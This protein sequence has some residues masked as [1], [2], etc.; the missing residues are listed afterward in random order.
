MGFLMTYC[1]NPFPDIKISC[2]NLIRAFC[3]YKWGVEAVKD[4]AGLL[5]Y[6]M[7]RKCEFDKEV[8]FAKYLVIK[9][10]AQNSIFDVQTHIQL[11][12]FVNQGPYYLPSNVQVSLQ[13]D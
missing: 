8:K 4:T 3:L 12:T 7:D 6:L 10:L 1:K 5:E 2:L 13:T 11:Q 9:V